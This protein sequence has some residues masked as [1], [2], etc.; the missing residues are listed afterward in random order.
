[1]L[2]P[3]A[4]EYLTREDSKIFARRGLCVIEGSWNRISSISEIQSKF[5]R[6][7]PLI[8]PS[9]P[10]NFGKPGK[11]S[12]AEATASALYIMGFQDRADE[13]MSKFKWGA[14]FIS[15][16]RNLL[17]DYSLCKDNNDI[18]EVEDSYF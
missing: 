15:M 16:N 3:F 11:L 12:S 18:L 2:S 10:V 17:D 6:V 1:M 5:S 13:V 7:L 8:V 14:T 9:N 4:H